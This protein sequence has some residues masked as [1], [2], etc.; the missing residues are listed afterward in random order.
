MSQKF[1]RGTGAV[2]TIPDNAI[3]TYPN[4]DWTLSIAVTFDGNFTADAQYLVSTGNFDAST[5]V[6]LVYAGGNPGQIYAYIGSGNTSCAMPFSPQIV[7]GETYIL[8]LQRKDGVVRSKTCKL[9]T[10]MPTDGSAVK[11]S[12]NSL[13]LTQELNGTNFM[14][15][16]RLNDRAR[17]SNQSMSRAFRVDSALTDFDIAKL[18]YGYQVTDLGYTP[19]W[20][21]RMND[22][23][24]YQDLSPNAMKVTASVATVTG[25]DPGFASVSPLPAPPVFTKAPAIIGSPTVGVATSFTA[26]TATGTPAPTMSYQWLLDDVAISGAVGATYTPV[27]ADVGKTLKIRQTATNTTNGTVNNVSSTSAGATVVSAAVT[28]TLTITPPA[29][30][31][32]YQRVNGASPVELSGTWSGTTPVRV[33]YQLYETNGTTVRKAWADAGATFTVASAGNTWSASPVLA[34]M[35]RKCKIAARTIDASGNVLV[36]TAVPNIRFG[37][38]DMIALVGSSAVGAWMNQAY[39]YGPGVPDNDLTSYVTGDGGWQT[40]GYKTGISMALEYLSG[41][42]GVVTGAAACGVPGTTFNNWLNSTDAAWRGLVNAVG[43]AGNKLSGLWMSLGSNDTNTLTVTSRQGHFNRIKQLIDNVRALGNNPTMPVLIQGMNRRTAHPDVSDAQ[44][45]INAEWVRG[46]ESDIAE[47]VANVLHLQTL[48]LVIGGDGVHLDNASIY[49]SLER[50]RFVY[51]EK[52]LNGVTLRGPK[53]GSM[54]LSGNVVTV[55]VL[56]RGSTDWTPSA[57]TGFVAY[58]ADGSI[59]SS[60]AARV[61]A[62]TIALTCASPPA[63]VKYLPGSAPAV[64]TP[65]YGNTALA[66]PMVAEYTMPITAAGISVIV[67][68]ATAT[69]STNF[70]AS[71]TG[72]NSPPQTVTWTASAG[73]ISSSGAFTAPAQTSSVQT[74][75]IRATSTFD[76][77]QSGTATVTIAAA[78]VPVVSGVIVSPGSAN[79]AGGG[80]QQFTASVLGSNSPSQAVSW[81]SDKGAISSSGLLSVPA[82]TSSVQIINVTATSIADPTKSGKSVVTIAAAEVPP[83]AGDN[84]TPSKVRTIKIKAASGRFEGTEFW[85]MSNPKKPVGTLDIDSTVDITLDWSEVMLDTGDIIASCNFLPEGM[86]ASGAHTDSVKSLTTIFVRPTAAARCKFTARVTTASTPSR[87]YDRTV[88]FIVEE[89]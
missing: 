15:G 38:G 24:D 58:A 51:A 14:I 79:L 60:T 32:I 72:P 85:N 40:Y 80:T 25:T 88:E 30:E 66:L 62:N 82:A 3:L 21:I 1:V 16:D 42:S 2:L 52:V 67:S 36:T 6:N 28:N 64:G 53:I 17:G 73:T 19:A 75:T 63:S 59:I 81:S 9:Q 55:Q 87:V 41:R 49:A 20:Y 45:E 31:R 23:D 11:T 10:A 56:H 77:T 54:S 35:A 76:T 46:A 29:N 65:V 43:M 78:L 12:T 50:N 13:A 18:A 7:A 48:D 68:P 22:K 61:D 8:V 69:G 34:Q 4:S 27:A 39:S 86:I 37:V 26:G 83:Q 44:F 89:Q 70:S 33:E 57:P 84:F 71:V 74:I 5:A 47:Q